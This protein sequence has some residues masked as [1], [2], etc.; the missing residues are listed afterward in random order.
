MDGQTDQTEKTTVVPD[1]ATEAPAVATELSTAEVAPAPEENIEQ[2]VSAQPTGQV[3]EPASQDIATPEAVTTAEQPPTP[4]VTEAQVAPVEPSIVTPIEAPV[5]LP[6][7]EPAATIPDALP[8]PEVIEQPASPVPP[9][10]T[11]PS[12]PEQN[13]DASQRVLELTDEELLAAVRLFQKKNVLKIQ[14]KGV[15]F[16]KKRQEKRREAVRAFVATHPGCQLRQIAQHM[17]LS[18][19]LTAHYVQFLVRS[20]DVTPEG[21][22]AGRRY[23]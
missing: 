20:G 9:T 2:T 17:N 4:P 7:K 18:L 23:R 10:T 11:T 3:E 22:G 12:E 6:S 8:P 15:A 14:S 5:V 21:W 13:T 16:R 1:G 19:Q